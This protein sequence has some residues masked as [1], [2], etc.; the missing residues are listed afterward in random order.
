MS[1]GT[2]VSSCI[3]PSQI[4]NPYLVNDEAREITFNLYENVRII[5]RCVIPLCYSCFLH[6]EMRFFVV[7]YKGNTMEH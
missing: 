2:Y 3:F 1:I 5:N 6:Q 7:T 4:G